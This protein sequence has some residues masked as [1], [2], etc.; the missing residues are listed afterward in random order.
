[1]GVAK[2]LS[3]L[4]LLVNSYLDFILLLLDSKSLDWGEGGEFFPLEFLLDIIVVIRPWPAYSA[5]PTMSL[6]ANKL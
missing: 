1:M 3:C 4:I 5:P 2:L 6:V